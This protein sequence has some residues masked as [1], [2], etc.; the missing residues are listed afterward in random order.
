L[1]DLAIDLT[2]YPE[3]QQVLTSGEPLVVEDAGTHP[4]MEI[5]R[6]A[7]RRRATFATLGILPIL[8][9]G[10]PM[11]VLFLRSRKAGAFGA[12]ELAVCQTIA[13][14]MAIALRN[15]RILQS[16]RDHTQQVT[17]ARVEAEQR[18]KLFERYA[19]FFNSSADGIVVID[20]DSHLLFGNPKSREITSYRDGELRGQR[21]DKIVLDDQA[22]QVSELRKGFLRGR[23]PRDIDLRVHARDGR[24]LTLNVSFA[25]VVHEEGVVLCSF[26]DVTRQRE[27]EVELVKTKDSL[28]RVID[29]SA[30]AIVS[31]DMQ[32]RIM[33]FNQAAERIFGRASKDV[34]GTDVRRLHSE[35][36]MDRLI[37]MI[38]KG[39]G[40]VGGVR[41]D[42]VDASDTLVPV[43]FSGA[44]IHEGDIEVGCVGIFT[45]L[46]EKMR[47]EQQ[48]Q[49]AQ[50][51][52]LAQERQAVVAELAGA[53]AHEL[54][55]PLTSVLNYATLLRRLLD[56]GTQASAAAAVIEAE[57]DRM[58][59]IVRKIGTITKYET[60]SY[61]GKQRILDL[62]RACAAT[63]SEAPTVI[64]G[65]D[66][67]G[68]RSTS[69]GA[70]VA[71][72][73]PPGTR[74]ERQ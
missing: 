64:E 26:R 44:F 62:D 42:I 70:S 40:R 50:E 71:F 56:V 38:R 48:L 22:T 3:I 12:R 41:A 53:A 11:G 52:I 14:T 72:Q 54:N 61:V 51:Q 58:A 29:A 47:M 34:V 21:L 27:V 8:N 19:D 67:P 5:V 63:S 65:E 16:L 2:K 4:L 55:Q 69:S 73:S 25:S 31:C 28:Q 32:G 49:Q 30:D 13:N 59:E 33:L 45:D 17:V 23:F 74:G 10:R 68:L 66:E 1:R 15:A 35:G 20:S 18:M 9:E 24:V 39:G 37:E 36:T 6:A 60:K 46:R 57:A 43:S 7:G